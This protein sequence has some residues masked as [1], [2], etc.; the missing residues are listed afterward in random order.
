[1]SQTSINVSEGRLPAELAAALKPA[2]RAALGNPTRR[3]IVRFLNCGDRA[4]TVGEIA[5]HFVDFTVSEIGYHV[6]ILERSGSVVAADVDPSPSGGRC[7]Y[8][9]GVTDNQQALAA[10]RATQQWDRDHRRTSDRRSAAH[11]TMFR[12]PRPCQTIRLGEREGR[13]Q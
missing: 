9:S 4:L 10:L 11:L 7:R 13:S 6:R 2:L 1:M 5:V 8:F 12:I 3:E